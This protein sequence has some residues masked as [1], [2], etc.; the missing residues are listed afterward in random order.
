[1]TPTNITLL[2]FALAAILFVVDVLPMG[3]L[4]FVVPISLHFAGELIVMRHGMV[5][6]FR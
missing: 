3:L 4:V 2:I 1:M 6:T 5:V